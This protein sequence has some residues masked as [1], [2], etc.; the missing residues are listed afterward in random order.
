ME[1]SRK[2]ERVLVDHSLGLKSL[3]KLA[4]ILCLISGFVNGAAKSGLL[5][6]IRTKRVQWFGSD[7]DLVRFF[8]PVPQGNC[9]QSLKHFAP[10]DW[11]VGLNPDGS[12]CAGFDGDYPLAD[13]EVHVWRIS[14]E[15]SASNAAKFWLTLSSDERE[16]AE[17]FHFEV[18]RRRSV[19]A[20]GVLRLLL[21]KVLNLPADSLRFEYDEF[22]KPRLISTQEQRL[23]FNVSHSGDLIL[24][25][26]TKDRAVGVDVERIRAD[27]DLDKVAA[28]FFSPN[29]YK[30]LG[31]L[32]GPIR[33]EAFFACWTRKEAYLK[34]RGDGLS[35]PLD[36]FDVSFLPNEEARLLETRQDPQE[37][38]RWRLLPVSAP[39]GYVATV[40]AQG[41]DW[42]L[43]CRDWSPALST[44]FLF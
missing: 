22:G 24:I 7:A 40:A 32:T 20:R 13:D 3:G 31:L 28:R 2:E 26:I 14:L 30:S 4:A 12:V 8:F 29:E 39:S 36:Q 35:M 27:I 34:A 38:E 6:L 41:S 5:A 15:L 43:S 17:R 44:S 19:V 1:L 10:R 23:R 9:S 21:G 18:D 37:A 16:R 33:Y 11:E 25:A 42:K